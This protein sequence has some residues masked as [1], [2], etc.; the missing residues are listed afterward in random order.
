[1]RI[2]HTSQ[3]LWLQIHNN[4]GKITLYTR[5]LENVTRQFPDVAETVKKGVKGNNFIL[6]SEIIGIDPKTKKWLPFQSVSQRIKRKYDIERI[7][8]EVPVMINVFDVMS[9]NNESL[10]NAPFSRRRHIV[11]K[12]VSVVPENIQPAK[13]IVTDNIEVAEKFYKESLALGN[14]GIMAK[15]LEALYN[16]GS[17]VG[18]GVKIK[19]VLDTLD[20]V[21]VKADYGEGKRAGWLTSYTV[22]CYDDD[23][24]NFLEVGKVSTGLKE[25]E[26]G[27]TFE[28]MTK[29]LK[30]LAGIQSGKEVIITPK[31]VI[32]VA[33]EEVQKSPSYAS[34]FALRFPRF[35]KIRFDK[36]LS[37][38]NTVKDIKKMFDTQRGRNLKS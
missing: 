21:I 1:M 7:I 18:H 29:M 23:K 11:E 17:R 32:E 12:I 10:I 9:Y 30:P 26:E 36:P 38:I 8:K 22:A 37:E 4:N 19:P 28:D 5:R 3:S 16:P 34:G 33:Y 24:N 35:I 13:Q 27:T 2:D 14:E 15:N 31:V 20:L 6:D 25:K